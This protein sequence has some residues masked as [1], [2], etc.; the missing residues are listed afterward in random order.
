MQNKGYKSGFA[1]IIGRP[2][3]GKSTLM[4]AMV[5]DKVAI[6]SEKAQT[7]RDRIMGVLSG[8]GYQAVFLDT[9][10]IHTPRSSL[11]HSMMKSVESAL[12]DTEIIIFLVDCSDF[13]EADEK[14]LE[15][16]REY[17]KASKILVINKIDKVGREKLAA[18]LARL[19]FFPADEVIPLSAK[20]GDGLDILKS[21]IKSLLPEGPKYFPEDYIT[22]KPERFLIAELI[23]EK[24][25]LNLRDEIPHGIGVEIMAI[26]KAKTGVVHIE[27][28]L[29]CEKE[30]HKSIIIGKSGSMIG[31]IGAAARID[32][33]RL[34]GSRANLKLWV[35]VVPDWRNRASELR[36]L[37]YLDD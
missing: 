12:T 4:N 27:A 15:Q 19:A 28:T 23:R 33:E 1:A 32:I 2:N 18:L 36:N 35:K 7:T 10:G 11:G 20:T 21:A 26:D 25:L 9:P 13:R 37:G 17:K 22:D 30:S 8:D 24:A 16:Y 3:V 14:L 29:Y 31:R 6:V 5:G 34:L